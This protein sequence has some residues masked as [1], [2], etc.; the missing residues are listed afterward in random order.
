MRLK[1]LKI[2]YSYL[3]IFHCFSNIKFKCFLF[4]PAKI[5]I[6][7]L[8]KTVKFQIQFNIIYLI[9]EGLNNHLVMTKLNSISH[10][11]IN[12][13]ENFFWVTLVCLDIA[14]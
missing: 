10:L 1:F 3:Q 4:N 5:R 6:I 2:T 11:L 9:K 12:F 7:S 14:L 13:V 8:V